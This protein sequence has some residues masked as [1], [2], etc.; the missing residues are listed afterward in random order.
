MT[1]QF[2]KKHDLSDDVFKGFMVQGRRFYTNEI[3]GEFD[4]EK[5]NKTVVKPMN[6]NGV[7]GSSVTHASNQNKTYLTLAWTVPKLNYST[8]VEFFFT[9]VQN[10]TKFW[11]KQKAQHDV[12]VKAFYNNGK[13]ST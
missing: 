11:V 12:R 9:L 6:C 7:N 13:D 2:I 5:N 8:N 1:L 4:M 3:L 10:K